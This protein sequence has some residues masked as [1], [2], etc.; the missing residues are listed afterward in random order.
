M[1]INRDDVIACGHADDDAETLIRG[2]RPLLLTGQCAHITIHGAPGVVRNLFIVGIIGLL[3]W[4]TTVI[5][6]WSGELVISIGN[7][8]D[9]GLSTM[10]PYCGIGFTFTGCWMVWDSKVGKLRNRDRFFQPLALTGNEQVLDLG[11]GRGPLLIGAA[12][13]LIT[14]K[15]TGVDLWQTVDLSG[16]RPEATLEDARRE[17]LEDRS[18]ICLLFGPKSPLATLRALSCLSLV[19]LMKPGNLPKADYGIDAPGVVRN[20]FIVGIIGLLL[21]FTTV[22]HVWSGE[23]VI[24][25]GRNSMDFGL[26]TMGLYCGIGFTFT[27]CWMVWD[28][29]V[30]K[31][32]NRDRFFQPL[33]L[34]GNEQVLD[35]GC[36]RGLLLI[37]AAKRLITGK[38]TGVDIWQTVDLSGNRPEATLENA[39][40]EGLEDRVEVKTADMR[41]LPFGDATF[42]CVVS[43]AAIHNI[44]STAERARAIREVAR[45]LKPGGRALI[46]DIR[47]GAEY[48]TVFSEAG[49]G[50]VK[51][52]GS[53]LVAIFTLLI[54]CGTL[55]P[56]TLLVK[57]PS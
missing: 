49:C 22:I 25:I 34:T 53:P 48:A 19:A 7:S 32:R 42:D 5:H 11:C 17:G 50:E 40:R 39:R 35:L 8:M 23:L 3:L 16:N 57:K 14:S 56:V 46:E 13:R 20:L 12:K 45:V 26:S 29:K 10:G 51:S 1:R 55:R 38:A 41:E 44:T 2:F 27:G 18:W 4:F 37:G 9:F 43:R 47:H 6:V 31:L 21:W 33:A 54:T 15:A 30:G 36:G 28:S 24:P 52:I